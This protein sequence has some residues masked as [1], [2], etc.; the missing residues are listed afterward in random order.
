MLI[1][2]NIFFTYNMNLFRNIILVIKSFYILKD[3]LFDL[4]LQ[5][6]YSY[7][8]QFLYMIYIYIYI[9]IYIINH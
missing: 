5:I 2:N 7:S 3:F 8:P 9:Y 4:F 6:L 1:E